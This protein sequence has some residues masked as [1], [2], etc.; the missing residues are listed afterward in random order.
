MTVTSA[1]VFEELRFI[2]ELLGAEYLFLL[3][4]AR[5]RPGFR[6]RT[7]VGI[8]A[9]TLLSQ[10][11]FLVLSLLYEMP[12]PVRSS[13]V[14]CWYILLALAT[15]PFLRRCF[16]LTASDGL[17]FCIAGYS[18]Q[19]I[20]YA[21]VHELLARIIWRELPGNLPLYIFIT[22]AHCLLIYLLTYL[23]FAEP[24]RQCRGQMLED[25]VQ[26]ILAHIVLLSFLM[27][28][29]FTSQ[30]IF[31]YGGD[32]RP[33]GAIVSVLV[34]C[35]MLGL[36]YSA[37]RAVR[38]RQEQST[39]EQMLRDSARQFWLTKEMVEHI[40]RT[41]HDL[42]HNLMVLKTIDEGERQ[43]YIE[44]T[45]RSIAL[46][47]ELVHSDNEVLNTILAEKCLY[48]DRHGINLSCAVDGGN[49]EGIAVLD[50]YALLGNAIDNAIES[51]SR[52]SEPEKRVISIT[53]SGHNSFTSIQT[54]NYYEGELRFQDRLPVTTKRDMLSHGIGLKSIR[55]LAEKYGGSLCVSA[56]NHIFTLQIMLPGQP[57]RGQSPEGRQP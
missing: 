28:C 5:R 2:W 41:C 17:Y 22:L 9:F 33:L 23:V 27:I 35:L 26:R 42:K 29:T 46:Y 4:F 15:I 21:V 49:L 38:S 45:E 30:H 6:I 43:R 32:M 25:N 44:E 16:Q 11:Y 56:E 7:V 1:Q 51:V 57:D 12:E 37:L 55:Y 52:L 40:N 13:A 10:G 54:N 50:L 18:A 14:A 47:H 19:H 24:L 3:P 48:C 34:C 8:A 36:E 20:V 39:I 53:I 31:E